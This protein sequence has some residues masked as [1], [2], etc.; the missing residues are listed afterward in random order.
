MFV[1]WQFKFSNTCYFFLVTKNIR[2]GYALSK[3]K[4]KEH[5]GNKIR[6]LCW[7]FYF[8]QFHCIS[9]CEMRE[10][11]IVFL[12]ACEKKNWS[13][14]LGSPL[15]WET[16]KPRF[17]LE[18]LISHWNVGPP[19]PG[20]GFSHPHWISV[21]DSICLFLFDLDPMKRGCTNCFLMMAFA[22]HQRILK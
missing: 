20:L 15:Q 8:P 3:L 4:W 17:P 9:L 2:C 1:K 22:L 13:L 11:S 18:R 5:F 7:N 12:M 14:I 19:S 21:L 10:D 6:W 16:H